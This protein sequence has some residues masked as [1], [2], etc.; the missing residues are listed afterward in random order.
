M[1]ADDDFFALGRHSLLAVTLVERLREVGATLSVHDIFV[2]PAVEGLLRMSLSSVRDALDVV[3]PIR[4]RGTRPPILCVHPGGGV[5]WCYLPLARHVWRT[6]RCT[7][8]RRAASTA[9]PT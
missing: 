4:V 8:F 3:L 2:A 5:S 1:G 6:S 7:G 9:R